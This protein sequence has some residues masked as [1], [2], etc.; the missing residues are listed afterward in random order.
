MTAD[1]PAVAARDCDSATKREG[2]FSWRPISL[3]V[4]WPNRHRGELLV[5]GPTGGGTWRGCRRPSQDFRTQSQC[6]REA[7]LP[8]ISGSTTSVG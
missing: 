3:R 6:S 4:P 2:R 1:L 8:W 5:F 7:C